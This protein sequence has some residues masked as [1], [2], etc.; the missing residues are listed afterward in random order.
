MDG[1][2]TIQS[3]IKTVLSHFL[4]TQAIYLFGSWNT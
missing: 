3:I 1:T 2:H 4:A